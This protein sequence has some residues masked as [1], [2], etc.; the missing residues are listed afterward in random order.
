M[1]FVE[2]I[3]KDIQDVVEAVKIYK[4][5]IGT[6]SSTFDCLFTRKQH[7]LLRTISEHNQDKLIVPLELYLD[8]P[9]LLHR[10]RKYRAVSLKVKLEYLLN[11]EIDSDSIQVLNQDEK[12]AIVELIRNNIMTIQ[13]TNKIPTNREEF[14]T[15]LREF[16]SE[17]V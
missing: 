1:K 16:L 3:G 6:K 14:F 13:R 2:L 7:A 4:H 5:Y 8:L 17:S 15:L 10:L 11:N 12:R 9:I